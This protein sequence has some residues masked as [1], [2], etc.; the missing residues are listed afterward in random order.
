MKKIRQ[1]QE[2]LDISPE[3]GEPPKHQPQMLYIGCID[4]R[5]DPIRDIGIGQGRALI[6]RN[7]GALVPKD[8]LGGNKASKTA[9]AQ[10]ENIP[11]NV[12]VGAAVEFFLNHIPYGNEKM[13]HIV[14]SG[15]TYCGGLHACLHD[16]Y[17]EEDCHLPQYLEKLEGLRARILKKAKA[18]NW[19]EEQ[20][21][22]A[23]EEESVRQ[24][25][26]NLRTYPGVV[27]AEKQ[28]RLEL[29][30]W[31]IDTA[32]KRIAEMNQETLVFEPMLAKKA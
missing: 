5:L 13:K 3:R 2:E 22:H 8:E 25:I 9:F 4:A 28:G 31:V 16:A 21:I 26:A 29:H 12:S 27:Q 18:E 15:H 20:I 30:G 10:D 1:R 19:T 32:T 7:I 23:M 17:G 6:F 11:Q 14:V 24:S